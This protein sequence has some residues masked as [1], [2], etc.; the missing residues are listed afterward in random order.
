VLELAAECRRLRRLCH[1]S[2][3][4]VSGRRRGV[5]LEEELD[6]GQTFRDADEAAAFEAE[7]LVRAAAR[8]LPVT[9]FRPGVVVGDVETGELA[10]PLA[11]AGRGAAPLHLV[12]VNY[13]VD[14]AYALSR[15]ERAAG[16]TFH[17]VDPSPFSARQVAELIARA[18][19]RRPRSLLPAPL[20]RLARGPLSLLESFDHLVYYNSRHTLAL[21]KGTGIECPTFDRYVDMLVRHAREEQ[22][23]RQ[24]QVEDEV[25][26]PFE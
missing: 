19:Q 4:A 15:D 6:E 5:I 21:L 12:P 22:A 13:L 25:V 17:L 7:K 10:V 20:A 8:R 14:A 24:R 18:E 1:W 2:T 26:D 3:I 11:L 23:A 9:V 16:G